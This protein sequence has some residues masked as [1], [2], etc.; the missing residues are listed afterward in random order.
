M[1]VGIVAYGF[2]TLTKN[3]EKIVYVFY[4]FLTE[5]NAKKKLSSKCK[6]PGEIGFCKKY[7]YKS[8]NYDLQ[9]ESSEFII[10]I[11]T[12][13]QIIICIRIST[14]NYYIPCDN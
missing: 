6:I 11:T 14:I 2:I 13:S 1:W 9:K 10:A 7:Y 4:E 3:A 8:F 12:I 5:F